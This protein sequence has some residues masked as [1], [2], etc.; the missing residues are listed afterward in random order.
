MSLIESFRGYPSPFFSGINNQQLQQFAR[1]HLDTQRAAVSEMRQS[2]IEFADIMADEL[3]SYSRT[4][5]NSI[6][7]STGAINETISAST[8]IIVETIATSTEIINDSI[9]ASTNAIINTLK[10][11]FGMISE[12]VLRVGEA[13]C[14]DLQDIKWYLNQQNSAT[15]QI[16][17][18]LQNSRNNEAN[19]LVKQGIKQFLFQDYIQAEKCFNKALEYDSTDYQL[20]MNLGYLEIQ[21]ENPLKA[22]EYFKR[23]L[24]LPDNLGDEDKARTKLAIARLYYSEKDYVKALLFAKDA[25][26][27]LGNLCNAK[28]YYTVAVY[29]ALAED[30]NQFTSFL[31]QAI[32]KDPNY[33]A[34]SLADQELKSSRTIL[35]TFLSS[36]ISSKIDNVKKLYDMLQNEIYLIVQYQ[37]HAN[38]AWWIVQIE[39]INRAIKNKGYLDN[40]SYSICCKLEPMLQDLCNSLKSIHSQIASKITSKNELDNISQK[41]LSIIEQASKLISI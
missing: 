25:N 2:T 13:L 19:Q 4:I 29:A 30:E 26:N 12:N 27:L 21:K 38:F 33:F 17:G 23:A 34:I 28:A 31:K 10:D 37:I 36:F 35:L 16:L 11:G 6:I 39:N 9:A 8:G 32:E 24:F 3:E 18:V 20:L 14:L 1:F 22:N 5:E 15:S 7:D 41:A 40:P